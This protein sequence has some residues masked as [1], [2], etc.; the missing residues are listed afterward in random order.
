MRRVAAQVT[1]DKD[2]TR[3][4]KRGST[5]SNPSGGRSRLTVGAIAALFFAV[6]VV[7]GVVLYMSASS[8]G[9]GGNGQTTGTVVLLL[10]LAPG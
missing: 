2:P 5:P 10:S 1:P 9:G 3:F 4:E 7:L 6:L 8:T